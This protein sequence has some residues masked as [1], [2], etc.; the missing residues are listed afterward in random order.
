M[1]NAAIEVQ[2][3]GRLRWHGAWVLVGVAIMGWT[4]WMALRPDPDITL[5]FPLGDKCLHAVTFTCLMGWWGNVYRRRPARVWAALVCL[6]FGVFIEFAQWLSPPRDADALDVLADS[7]G[8]VLALLL[9]R[10]P[11]AR[12]LTG[13]EAGLRR[14]RTD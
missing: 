8:I 2:P 6:A 10:T 9:L 1:S 12:V 3:S 7:V 5:D 11:L 14:L 4:L 13:V